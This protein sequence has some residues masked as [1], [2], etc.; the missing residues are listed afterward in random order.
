MKYYWIDEDCKC[1]TFSYKRPIA[2]I[3]VYN[4]QNEANLVLINNMKDE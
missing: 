1:V 3:K 2:S 4:T